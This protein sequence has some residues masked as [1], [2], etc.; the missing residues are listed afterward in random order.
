MDCGVARLSRISDRTL[1]RNACNT[2]RNRHD[3]PTNHCPSTY[4]LCEQA[5]SLRR[6]INVRGR[7][8]GESMLRLEAGVT[9]PLPGCVVYVDCHIPDRKELLPCTHNLLL[10]PHER[11]NLQASCTHKRTSGMEAEGRAAR[12]SAVDT[13]AV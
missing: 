10:Y 1:T 5:N 8:I 6:A 9:E 12:F 2:L 3:A 7:M 4:P 13:G 11:H